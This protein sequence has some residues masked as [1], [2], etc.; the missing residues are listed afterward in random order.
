MKL[1]ERRMLFSPAWVFHIG[2]P[3]SRIHSVRNYN[4]LSTYIVVGFSKLVTRCMKDPCICTE[5]VDRVLALH[6][7]ARRRVFVFRLYLFRS[8]GDAIA[9]RPCG[10]APRG[11]TIW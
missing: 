6:C 5:G 11:S 9:V 7:I 8:S 1:K 10:C 2:V 4:L 3:A